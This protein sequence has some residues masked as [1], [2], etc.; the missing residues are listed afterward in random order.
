MYDW[1]NV[2][3][4]LWSSSSCSINTCT[5][6]D[7]ILFVI[8]LAYCYYF[9]LLLLL[10][11]S[12]MNYYLIWLLLPLLFNII[13]MHDYYCYCKKYMSIYMHRIIQIL[14][15][16]LGIDWPFDSVTWGQCWKSTC[17]FSAFIAWARWWRENAKWREERS[18]ALT[19][20]GT[21]SSLSL[22]L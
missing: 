18:P 20:T 11:N 13:M 3:C 12:I 21:C 16:Q 1:R 7:I 22:F 2:L 6:F 15:R 17:P 8:I 5:C 19:P 10:F 9:L 14:Y 4:D